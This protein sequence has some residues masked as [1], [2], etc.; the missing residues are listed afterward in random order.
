MLVLPLHPPQLLLLDP[1]D[2]LPIN[3]KELL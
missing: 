1:L 3:N 2:K